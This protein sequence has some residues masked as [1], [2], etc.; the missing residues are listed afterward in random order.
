MGGEN[1]KKNLGK[2]LDILKSWKGKRPDYD[3]LEPVDDAQTED[4][5]QEE[6]AEWLEHVEKRKSSKKP[7]K[8]KSDH[9]QS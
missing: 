8:K 7:V 5:Y 9:S 6:Q 4:T 1:R 3:N 2:I